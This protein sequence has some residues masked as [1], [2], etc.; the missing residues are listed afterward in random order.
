MREW[1]GVVWGLPLAE[2]SAAKLKRSQLNVCIVYVYCVRCTLLDSS[3]TI[4]KMD[5]F[6]KYRCQLI[7]QYL[8]TVTS[9][10]NSLVWVTV[11][12]FRDS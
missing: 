11:C 2:D 8:T 10:A 1:K 6:H 7:C 3:L 12:Y 4:N 9:R 5:M